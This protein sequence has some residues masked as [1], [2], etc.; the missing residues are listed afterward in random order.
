[1]IERARFGS[2]TRP[3]CQAWPNMS[4]TPIRRSSTNIGGDQQLVDENAHLV[5]DR[6]IDVAE[7]TE[8][9]RRRVVSVHLGIDEAALH[10]IDV[11]IH[12]ARR[13]DLQAASCHDSPISPISQT[14]VDSSQRRVPR[15]RREEPRPG[16]P[17]S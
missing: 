14:G 5:T 1:M 3:A 16:R 11:D 4:A 8:Q 9:A 17:P 7:P 15:V 6:S 12:A 2:T 13:L 10:L